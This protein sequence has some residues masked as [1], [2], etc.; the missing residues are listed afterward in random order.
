M[1]SM[2]PN[3]VPQ[4][5]ELFMQ[6]GW[7]LFFSMTFPAGAGFTILA[8]LLRMNI[9]L[10]GMSEYKKKN[11]P[12][13]IKDIGIWMDLL[14]FI[15]NV[16]IVVCM[17]MIMFT[18][19]KLD[20]IDPEVDDHIMYYIAF[21][22]LHVIMLLKYVMQELIEDEPEW[23][24]VDRAQTKG[25]VEQVER[26]NNDKKLIERMS[27]HYTKMDMLFD[28]LQ[29]QHQNLEQSSQLVPIIQKGCRQWLIR[30]HMEQE[31]K[32]RRERHLARAKEIAE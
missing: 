5:N 27:K 19:K 9:E 17:Y 28:L 12:A 25:R 26:D 14:E 2:P 29:M 4:Y 1:E 24:T 20:T 15:A 23:V 10:K 31:E 21:G 8:G 32:L 22:M 11:E 7:I 6:L 18:S 3:L 30:N 13:M 16:G